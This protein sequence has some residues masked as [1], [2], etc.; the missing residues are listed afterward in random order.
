MAIL[1]SIALARVLVA[2]DDPPKPAAPDAAAPAP[3]PPPPPR[4]GCARSTFEGIETDPAC[5]VKAPSEETV[6]AS[7]K[8]LSV[9]VTPDT[10]ETYAG[11]T[12]HLTVTIKNTSPTEAMVWLEATTRTTGVRTDWARLVGVPD[13]HPGASDVPRLFISLTTTDPWDRDVD[14]VPTVGSGAPPAPVPLG[15]RLRPGAKVRRVVE[16]FALR[17]PA[18]P[19]MFQND[20]GHRFYPKTAALPLAPG[21]YGVALDLPFFA[22]S[23]EERKQ[24]L[25]LKVLA[26]P[27]LD[28]GLPR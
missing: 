13:R 28:A 25:K 12:V 3:P 22:L 27:K 10:T 16:W 8:Q 24:A 19:P 14:A 11:G 7:M 26:M 6:R 18:P 1:L 21:E 15:V 17:I 4:E 20:A 23:K 5:V 9:T 2:C